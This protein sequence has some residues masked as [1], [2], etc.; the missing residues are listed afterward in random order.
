MSD[1]GM[2]ELPPPVPVLGGVVPYLTVDG[3]WD[4]AD[5]YVRAL[6]A[7]DM[8]RIPRDEKGRT[9]HVHLQVN[10]G[11]LML[12]DAYPDHGHPWQAPAGFMLHLQVDDVD[13]WWDRAVKAGMTVV[14]PL[15]KMFWGDRYGQL[16]DPY[17]VKWSM[18]MP[19]PG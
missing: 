11:S 9:M 13:A 2:P 10:G 4:A 16:L 1:Q 3:A 5:F 19:D 7:K 17:G 6:G 8:A 12:S 15:Q 14:T 18:A